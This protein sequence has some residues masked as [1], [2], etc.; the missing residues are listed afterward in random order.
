MKKLFTL[1]TLALMSIGSAWADDVLCTAQIPAGQ[2]GSFSNTT[3]ITEGQT[4]CTLKWSGLQAGDNAVT[5][6][7]V[8]YYKMG[9]NNAYVQLE[10]TSGGFVAG[11]VV[12]ATVTSNGDNKSVLLSLKSNDGNKFASAKVTK[13]STTDITYTL[14]AEDIE[15]DGSIKIFRGGNSN[16]RIAIFS[17]SG[18]RSTETYT[19]TFDAGAYG[20]CATA[21][22]TE[23]SPMAGVILPT[24]SPYFG[25]AF[26]GWYDAESAGTKIGDADEEYHPTSD[27]TLYAQYA[28]ISPYNTYYL[29]AGDEIAANTTLYFQDITMKYDAAEK[30]TAAE[31]VDAE[32]GEY[33]IKDLNENYVAT[34]SCSQ[35][36]WG[37]IFTPAEDGCLSVGLIINGGKT[38]SITNVTSFDYID[39]NA[40]IV[41]IAE[42]SWT[43]AEKF[44]GIV[45]INVTAGTTYKFSVAGSK[46]SLY[47]FEFTPGAMPVNIG[48]Y[49]WATLVS[50]SNLDFTDSDI[51]AYIVTDHNGNATTTTQVNK[52]A[53][54]TPVLLNAAKKGAYAIPVLF[55]DDFDDATGNL[56]VAGSGAEVD[57]G[58]GVTRYVLSTDGSTAVFK[59][60]NAT[61]ATV[62]AG[63][64]YLE[65]AEEIAAPVLSIGGETTGIET[66]DN[67][68][69]SQRECG[70]ARTIDN[71]YDLQGRRVAQPTKGLYIVNGKKVVIK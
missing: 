11:D 18:T 71:Y 35:N 9:S 13:G 60:I 58:S 19:V 49:G 21:S 65:F 32:T 45:S 55:T 41:T 8:D 5:I 2:E 6:G 29:A 51:K 69:F 64:A 47:G 68:Q 63:K 43:P 3:G 70:D 27:I 16:V 46:M 34:I 37:V 28:P 15:E 53:A 42:N 4:G 23:E 44:Y 59:K 38:F 22:L 14:K 66:I 1:L 20:T 7:S 36:G 48:E 56:L 26:L 25:Y 17:V 39:N 52:V 61:S 54:G 50:T 24:V 57:A 33:H 12:T 10:L 30:L 67:G 40:N 62:A 31:D